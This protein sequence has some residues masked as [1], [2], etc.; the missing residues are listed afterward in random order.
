[1]YRASMIKRYEKKMTEK[2]KC[3]RCKICIAIAFAVITLHWERSCAFVS[4]TAIFWLTREQ[5]HLKYASD[6]FILTF[7][8]YNILSYVFKWFETHCNIPKQRFI[9]TFLYNMKNVVST[10]TSF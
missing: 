6:F 1:M 8:E 3:G 10:S 2:L 5:Y 7:K 4:K 9:D